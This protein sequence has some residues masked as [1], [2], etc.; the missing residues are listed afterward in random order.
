[1][2]HRKIRT[3]ANVNTTVL[4]QMADAVAHATLTFANA[5]FAYGRR[6]H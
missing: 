4:D 2:G 6:G 3:T 5:A 1:M